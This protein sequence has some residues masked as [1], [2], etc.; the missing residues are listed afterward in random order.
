MKTEVFTDGASSKN[1]KKGCKSGIGVYFPDSGMKISVSCEKALADYLFTQK[2]S[3]NVGELMA[4]LLAIDSIKDSDK[5]NTDI[6]VYCDS[7]YC[8]SS[9]TVWYKKWE[10]N[11]WK[12]AKGDVKNQ[13]IIKKI[14]EVKSKFN[15]VYFVHVNSHLPE[16][17]DRS[18]KEW[19]LWNG[20]HQAD[21]LAT[22]SISGPVI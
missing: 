9:L 19:Y 17:E 12:T 18:S 1:G 21:Q 16:P 6:V 20:N 5:P 2:E 15:N 13:E 11:G 10:T 4:I 22:G 7:M 3:N 8:I 14:I